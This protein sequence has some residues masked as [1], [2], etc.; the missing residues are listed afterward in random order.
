MSFP[1]YVAGEES[2]PEEWI[3]VLKAS[4]LLEDAFGA[5]TLKRDLDRGRVR[6]DARVV[7]RVGTASRRPYARRHR[8]PDW[9]SGNGRRGR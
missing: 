2:E 6:Q 9:C 7:G 8:R 4:A 1:P 5:L 3:H